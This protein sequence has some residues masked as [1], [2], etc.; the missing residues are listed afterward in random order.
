MINP[1]LASSARR[2]MRSLR[3]PILI[4]LYG[5]M[6]LASGLGMAFGAFTSSTLSIFA[7]REGVT[8][9]A[10]MLAIQ[11]AMILLITPAMTAGS[12]AGER[13]RQTLDMLL[14]TNTGSLRIVAGKLLE[15]L[16]YVA[17]LL[18]AALPTMC[19]TLITGG[20]T[21]ADVLTGALFLLVTAFAALSVG[22]FA[23]AVFRRTVTA[24]VMAYLLVFLIGVVTLLP[25]VLGVSYI[26]S[27]YDDMYASTM[28]SSVAVIG[29]ADAAASGLSSGLSVNAF[30][31]SPAMGLMALI[32]D[33][34]GLLKSTLMDYSYT[35]YRIYDYLDFSAI[36][37]ENMAFMAGAGLLLDLL[38]ACFVRPREARLRRRSAKK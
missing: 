23:S 16:G 8:A 1:I 35:M 15:S 17:L 20:V 36:K 30:I 18:V 31:Y 34:T 5:A 3:T 14:V 37:W 9:Y 38:A 29:G 22:V 32:A 33:Q 7:M 28:A 10:A 26:G 24:T 2:R 27:H 25:M 21:L 19:L 6:I 4:T 11:F 13:E 12:I